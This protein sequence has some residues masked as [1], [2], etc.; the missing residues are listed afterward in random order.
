MN[1]TDRLTA[2]IIYLQGRSR[3]TVKDLS[4]RYGIS[5]RTVYRDLRA[6]QEAGV[7][8]GSEEGKGYFIVKGYHLPPV[9]FDK[10]EVA[11]LLAGERLME[12]WSETKLS[13]SYSAALDKIRSVLHSREKE[14]LDTLDQHIKTFSYA[15]ERQVETDYRIFV[16][17]QDAVVNKEVVAIE[18]YSPYKDQYTQRD[19]EPLGLLIRGNYWYLAGWCRLRTDYRMFRVDRIENYKKTGKKLADAPEHTLQEF[20]E[21]SLREEQDLEEVVVQFDEEMIRYLGDQKHYRGWV[22]E[23][24]VDGGVQMTFLTSSIEYFARW[25]LMW[26]NGVT[27]HQPKELKERVCEL[28]KELYQHHR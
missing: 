21:Q 9:M 5:S 26:G 14:Y 22:S 7:P 23:E 20:S 10:D 2:M 1:R 28:S 16:F 17:L 12:K 8:I 19:V 24:K 25:L 27:V 4:E 13:Q 18:Y 3:V 11:A 6:L 15:D